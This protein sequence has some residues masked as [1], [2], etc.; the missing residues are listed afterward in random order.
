MAPA[1]CQTATS[2]AGWLTICAS[3]A[4]GFEEV[5]GTSQVTNSD[6]P[7]WVISD[8][9]AKSVKHSPG[10]A[11]DV[12]NRFQIPVKHAADGNV[13]GASSLNGEQ[14]CERSAFL[15]SP[16]IHPSHCLPCVSCRRA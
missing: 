10:P 4:Q 11:V 12:E 14:T 16:G 5:N 6:I 8:A 15:N 3:L 9:Q 13:S 2:P 1:G 7:S